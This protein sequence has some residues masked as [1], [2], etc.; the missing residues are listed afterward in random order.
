MTPEVTYLPDARRQIAGKPGELISALTQC[1]SGVYNMDDILLFNS[2][3]YN[4]PLNP[5]TFLPILYHV[6]SFLAIDYLI[7]F[8]SLQTNLQHGLRSE[9]FA[10]A[11]LS[12]AFGN[13]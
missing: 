5:N 2:I 13:V 11:L 3:F 4:P 10:I 1:T 12:C 9:H 6:P 7:R 8:L